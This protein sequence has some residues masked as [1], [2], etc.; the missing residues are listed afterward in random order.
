M[1]R[2]FAGVYGAL[3]DL[4]SFS[5][6]ILIQRIIASAEFRGEEF[7]GFGDGYVE[8]EEREEGRRRRGRRG[9]ARAGVP[10]GRRVEAQAPGRRRRRLHRSQL[11]R[12]GRTH[13]TRSFQHEACR[14]K[15]EFFDRSRL[16]VLPL[17]ERVNDLQLDQLA[18]RSTTTPPA[19]AHP[20]LPRVAERIAQ[21]EN[22]AFS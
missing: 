19:F 20:D 10:D 2:Y 14:P 21:G 7:L 18:R 9:D 22:A 3:D 13:R 17:E 8:I 11:S 5:K 1:H 12:A 16:R 15:F 6:G 4:K